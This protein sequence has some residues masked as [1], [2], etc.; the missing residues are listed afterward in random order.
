ML[1]ENTNPSFFF[2]P[3]SSAPMPRSIR[4]AR[5]EILIRSRWQQQKGGK[6]YLSIQQPAI[7]RIPEYIRILMTQE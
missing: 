4:F 1:Y 6:L 7:Q 5:W 2:T 3:D